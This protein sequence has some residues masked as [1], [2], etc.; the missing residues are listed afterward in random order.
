[1]SPL[2]ASWTTAPDPPFDVR[3]LLVE[4]VT[5]SWSDSSFTVATSGGRTALSVADDLVVAVDGRLDAGATR[6]TTATGSAAEAI[7][8]AWRR[9][10]AD[11]LDALLG[12][13]FVVVYDRRSQR[14]EVARDLSGARPG[15]ITTAGGSHLVVTHLPGLGR[16]RGVRMTADPAWTAAYLD[17]RWPD[18]LS[19]P[20]AGVD[21]V[22]PGHVAVPE[23]AGWQQTERARWRL[24]EPPSRTARQAA[25]EFREI[26]DAAVRDRISDVTGPVAVTTSG[27]LDS[28][29]ALVTA[30]AVLPDADLHA[31]AIPFSDP[32]GDE[33]HL[34]EAV[35][36]AAGAEL[37]WVDVSARGPFGAGPDDVFGRYGAPPLAPNWFFHSTL[38]DAAV[39][40]GVHQ[41]LD[42]EDGDG[43]LGGNPS[44]LAD[45]AGRGHLLTWAREMSALHRVHDDSIRQLL[46]L[47][48]FRVRNLG[49][50]G[51]PGHLFAIRRRAYLRGGYLSRLMEGTYSD[52]TRVP[53]GVGHPF[54]DRRVIEFA[55]PLPWQHVV[56]GGRQ[57]FILREAMHGR[58]PEEIR[59]RAGKAQLSAPFERMVTG[60]QQEWLAAGL[61]A[62]RADTS[63]TFATV[64]WA[65]VANSAE[66]GDNFP[67]FRVAMVALWNDWLAQRR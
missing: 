56:S 41:V 48:K 66:A 54:L 2:A 67:G 19:T 33:R 29:S 37:H 8:G 1:V 50:S 64:N 4:A 65:F 34:Q 63:Q 20:Y 9:Q 13:L 12:D 11:A 32:L 18:A 49:R 28:T 55:L 61:A 39:A 22:L 21:A 52:W 36:R 31:L 42:G 26:F 25:D 30:R 43:V 62:A 38:E 6:A 57:K 7:A 45:L 27:G 16:A 59:M 24:A 47:S 35:A 58:L 60:P 40:A 15:F 23:G 53:G 10:G 5:Q 44:F 17:G 3:A 51:G 14:L 46:R